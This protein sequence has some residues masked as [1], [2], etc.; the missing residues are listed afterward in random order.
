MAEGNTPPVADLVAEKTE[1][2]LF[3]KKPY[4]HNEFDAT[5][6]LQL[7]KATLEKCSRCTFIYSVVQF[8]LEDDILR[9]DIPTHGVHMDGMYGSG[10][11][12]RFYLDYDRK[13]KV[14]EVGRTD[15]ICL[16][17]IINSNIVRY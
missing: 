6:Y 12:I 5:S 8:I 7:R 1:C 14:S 15:F 16:A 13:E 11:Y 9:P 10:R 3:R 4:L 2:A 17:G